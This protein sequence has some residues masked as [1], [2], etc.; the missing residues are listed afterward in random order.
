MNTDNVSRVSFGMMSMS[1]PL[2]NAALLRRV[3]EYHLE[4]NEPCEDAGMVIFLEKSNAVVAITADGLGDKSYIYAR[5]GS[6]LLCQSIAANL[7]QQ[8]ATA[9]SLTEITQSV[10]GGYKL[11]CRLLAKYF[12]EAEKDSYPTLFATTMV[13]SIITHKET[14]NIIAGDGQVIVTDSTGKIVDFWY[15]PRYTENGTT[16][17]SSVFSQNNWMQ[18]DKLTQRFTIVSTDGLKRVLPRKFWGGNSSSPE[19]SETEASMKPDDFLQKV[20]RSRLGAHR[21]VPQHGVNLERLV[22]ES[23]IDSALYHDDGA[24]VE[25]DRFP[26]KVAKTRS[27]MGVEMQSCQRAVYGAASSS[28]YCRSIGFELGDTKKAKPHWFLVSASAQSP[29]GQENV[30]MSFVEKLLLSLHRDCLGLWLRNPD[31]PPEII[32]KDAIVTL[33]KIANF[34]EVTSFCVMVSINGTDLCFLGSSDMELYRMNAIDLHTTEQVELEVLPGKKMHHVFQ[35]MHGYAFFCSNGISDKLR[36][37]ALRSMLSKTGVML[38]FLPGL[39]ELLA[40]TGACFVGHRR[41]WPSE[42]LHDAVVPRRLYW[43]YYAPKFDGSPNP[44]VVVKRLVNLDK[45]DVRQAVLDCG[46]PDFETYCEEGFQPDELET[47]LNRLWRVHFKFDMSKMPNWAQERLT[48]WQ[49]LHPEKV[50]EQ[51]KNAAELGPLPLT[52]ST[53]LIAIYADNQRIP[54]TAENPTGVR[55]TGKKIGNPKSTTKQSTGKTPSATVSAKP[56]SAVPKLWKIKDPDYGTFVIDNPGFAGAGGRPP[57]RRHGVKVKA[58]HRSYCSQIDDQG[59]HALIDG[60]RYP[61]VPAP[62]G[63]DLEALRGELIWSWRGFSKYVLT[64]ESTL[65]PCDDLSASIERRIERSE[66]GV[67]L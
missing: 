34:D 1:S 62:T 65:V 23:P 13:C 55:D 63:V 40:N 17:T 42:L 50:E 51:Y 5:H 32:G 36:D 19:A 37:S 9:L 67:Y 24:L 61:I 58:H 33:A 64:T 4:N 35:K 44:D 38:K 20:V 53:D 43:K 47:E 57:G 6:Q 56:T 26:T 11:F 2:A 31:A 27:L 22:H 10:K 25:V 7:A 66:H 46:Y 30:C 52:A 21:L 49:K 28:S 60:V 41:V 45:A 39:E 12:N 14:R 16:G 48:A 59:T 15:D 18:L 8:E 3:G 54:L 29:E